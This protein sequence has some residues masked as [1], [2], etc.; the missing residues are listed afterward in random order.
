VTTNA[1]NR[2]V[3]WATPIVRWNSI[4]SL[5]NG[6]LHIDDPV[7]QDTTKDTLTYLLS[8]AENQD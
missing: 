8:I 3:I 6:Q 2:F 7:D 4:P 5:S 1:T